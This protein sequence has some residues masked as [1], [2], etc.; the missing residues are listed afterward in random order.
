MRVSPSPPRH[1]KCIKW[2]ARFARL[3]ISLCHVTENANTRY[4]HKVIDLTVYGSWWCRQIIKYVSTYV[5]CF[6]LTAETSDTSVWSC[7]TD[8]VLICEWTCCSKV[9]MKFT[10]GI[11]RYDIKSTLVFICTGHFSFKIAFFKQQLRRSK[12]CVI[13]KTVLSFITAVNKSDN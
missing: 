12:L 3:V 1:F 6:I 9:I 4:L 2:A 5:T 11:L 7:S 10:W 8:L 13:V